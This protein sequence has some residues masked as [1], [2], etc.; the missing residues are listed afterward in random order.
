M[1]DINKS[2]QIIQISRNLFFVLRGI[3]ILI[4]FYVLAIFAFLFFPQGTDVL[5]LLLENSFQV[6]NP[7]SLFF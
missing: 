5:L 7:V 6:G 3:W 4:V 1:P 2:D